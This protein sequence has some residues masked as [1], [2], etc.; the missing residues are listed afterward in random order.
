M[1]PRKEL[2]PQMEVYDF[3][4]INW[5]PFIMFFQ[6]SNYKSTCCKRIICSKIL[7]IY[8]KVGACYK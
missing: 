7:Y 2:T 1:N 3:L 6:R 4:G 5:H 8:S